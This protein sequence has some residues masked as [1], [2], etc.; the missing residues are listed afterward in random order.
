[1][2]NTAKDQLIDFLIAVKFISVSDEEMFAS[3]FEQN[4]ESLAQSK[5]I[6]VYRTKLQG[7][8]SEDLEC[9]AASAKKALEKLSGHIPESHK[10][11]FDQETAKAD[12]SYWSKMA[13]WSLD[14]AVAL[15]FGKDP[16][17][18]NPRAMQK[19]CSKATFVKSFLEL[20]QLAYRAKEGG[21]LRG[22]NSLTNYIDWVR[23]YDLPFPKELEELVE[24]NL[25]KRIDWKERYEALVKEFDERNEASKNSALKPKEKKEKQLSTKERNTLLKLVVGMAIDGYGYDL[26]ASRSSMPREI[27][28]GLLTHNISID[29]DTVRNWLNEAKELV[30]IIGRETPSQNKPKSV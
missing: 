1:M 4:E 6:D 16:R 5:E 26:S 30:D 8:C 9:M 14:E 29:E 20:A 3:D 25:G 15:S 2:E 24:A 11:F 12:F 7:Q 18:V 19:T 17:V 22:M 23:K 21:E 13:S 28:A 27:A 10:E